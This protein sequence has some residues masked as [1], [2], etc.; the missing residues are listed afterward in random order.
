MSGVYRSKEP[1]L[2]PDKLIKA[3]VSDPSVVLA[4]YLAIAL[5]AGATWRYL[6]SCVKTSAGQH[7]IA[8]ADIK[9][10]PIPLP[11]IEEQRRI[12]ETWHAADALVTRAREAVQAQQQRSAALRQSILAAAFSGRLVPQDPSDEPASALLA[13]LAEQAAASPGAP[14]RRGRRAAS[15]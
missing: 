14:T 9:R 7:G 1:A 11:P 5:N 2:H 3:R 15:A 4:D 10:A 6:T 13:R 12:V 8:G